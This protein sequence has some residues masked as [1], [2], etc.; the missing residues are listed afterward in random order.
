MKVEVALTELRKVR[1][2]VAFPHES[3]VRPGVG[4]DLIARLAPYL[5][6]WGIMLVA[7]GDQP[8]AHAAFE[9]KELLPLLAETKLTRFDIDL[10]VP[11]ED[12]DDE[13]PF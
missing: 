7:E 1:L 2:V 9:T 13:L 8:H 10:D 3:Y 6:P 11:P 12:D 5:P 4:D